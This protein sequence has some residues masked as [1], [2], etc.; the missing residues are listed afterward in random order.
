MEMEEQLKLLLQQHMKTLQSYPQTPTVWTRA[1][2]VSLSQ[3]LQEK[4][5]EGSLLFWCFFL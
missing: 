5:L 3:Q 2:P 1:L 4:R